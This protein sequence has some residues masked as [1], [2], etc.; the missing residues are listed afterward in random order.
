MGNFGTI[1]GLQSVKHI[2]LVTR[3]I[4]DS[5]MPEMCKRK[6]PS[7]LLT[8]TSVALLNFG[9]VSF[10]YASTVEIY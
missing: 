3:S 6:Q 10:S 8:S 4:I 5:N 2:R 9:I 7:S 1:Q